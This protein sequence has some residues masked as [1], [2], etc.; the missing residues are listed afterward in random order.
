MQTLSD[1]EVSA[2]AKLYGWRVA[3]LEGYIDGKAS[4]RQGSTASIYQRVGIDEYCLGFRAAYYAGERTLQAV[5]DAHK[6]AGQ[7][8]FSR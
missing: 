1:D 4:R 5:E 8:S 3:Y 7:L 6:Q 2:L